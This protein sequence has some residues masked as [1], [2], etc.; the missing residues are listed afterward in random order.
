MREIFLQAGFTLREQPGGEL[1]L[2]PYV[3]RAAEMLLE[4]VGA[5]LI[6]PAAPELRLAGDP[7]DRRDL[8]VKLGLRGK[9]ATAWIRDRL[10]EGSIAYALRYVD[11]ATGCRRRRGY[12][13]TPMTGDLFRGAD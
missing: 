3:Y 1:E 10:R 4:A 8:E 5:E 7:I 12:F 13:T 11:P 9:A 2:N 6:K